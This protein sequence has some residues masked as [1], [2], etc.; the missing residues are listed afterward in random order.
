ME[1]I[2]TWWMWAGFAVFVVVA[3][4]IDLL[5]M[6][7]QGAHKVTMGE[8]VRWSLLW[9]SLAFVFVALL[10]WYLD[11]SQ[12]REVANTVSMQFITGYLVE[13]SL[14]VDNIFVFLMLFGYFAVP[15]QYQKRALII[16]IIG[17]I[18]LRTVLIL[19]GAWLLATFHWLLYVFGAFL[20]ITGVKMWFAAGQEPDIAT[21]PVLTLLKKRMR[22]TNHFD[23]EKLSTMVDGVK[24]YTPLFA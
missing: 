2:G 5:V 22:I 20:V 24:H 7:R 15:P 19:V 8:A 21:N 9:F 3:I 6:E 16:G 12:G 11:G 23:G 13:K 1:T 14:S 4:A 17:A 18:V 10:W